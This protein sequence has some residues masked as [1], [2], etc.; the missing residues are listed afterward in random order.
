MKLNKSHRPHFYFCKRSPILILQLNVSLSNK[1]HIM[2]ADFAPSCSPR[3]L[4]RIWRRRRR[5]PVRAAVPPA[6]ARLKRRDGLRR[7]A[8]DAMT[9][10]EPVPFMPASVVPADAVTQPPPPTSRQRRLVAQA[11]GGRRRRIVGAV[12]GK[13]LRIPVRWG[14][15]AAICRIRRR[16]SVV[17]RRRTRAWL[18]AAVVHVCWR[19]L[20]TVGLR[21][22]SLA[23]PDWRW[24]M[25]E[26]LYALRV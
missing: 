20:K 21:R 4:L 13:G 18:P 8:F 12:R 23:V 24:R 17:I 9:S 7:E 26:R 22:G 2:V 5:W 25:R 15:H 6:R 10:L 19:S 14:R 3:V 1:V 11:A 16:V